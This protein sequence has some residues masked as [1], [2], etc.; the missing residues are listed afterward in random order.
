M[1]SDKT[2]ERY[3]S[4]L[5]AVADEMKECLLP[6]EQVRFDYPSMSITVRAKGDKSRTKTVNQ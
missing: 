6:G 4:A 2:T 3:Y 1:I 5:Q